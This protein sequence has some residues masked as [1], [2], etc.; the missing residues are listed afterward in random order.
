M[1]ILSSGTSLI[2]TE[3]YKGGT[4]NMTVECAGWKKTSCDDGPGI[5]SVLFFQGCSMNCPGCQNAQTHRKGC[6]KECS[7]DE[8]IA[9]IERECKNKK[10]TISGGEP[11]EQLDALIAILDI[12]NLQ[13]YNICVYTGWS[14]NKVPMS[15]RERVSYLKCG[16][17]DKKRLNSSLMYVGSDNQHMYRNTGNGTLVEMDLVE[18]ECA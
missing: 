16:G 17:F 11:L 7:V 14:L 15:V 4:V 1:S 8:L 5:R 2:I 9:L 12:L 13:G 18:K 10:I 3:P 6:G